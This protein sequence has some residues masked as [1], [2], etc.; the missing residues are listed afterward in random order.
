MEAKEIIE[1][2]KLIAEFIQFKKTFIRNCDS[3]E[4]DYSIPDDFELIKEVEICIEEERGYG[5]EYQDNCMAR[6]LKFESSWDWLMPVVEKIEK[7]TVYDLIT[8]YDERSEFIGW[9]VHWF[10]LN[11][12]NE[13]LGYIE[14]K[15]FETKI[16][17]TW[18]AVVEFI[19]YHNKKH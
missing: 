17:A 6:D 3:I 9:S 10:T 11:T 19:K 12:N 16:N 13:I 2:N 14:D 1:G 4:Y 7:T 15:R 8:N 18:F 5:L